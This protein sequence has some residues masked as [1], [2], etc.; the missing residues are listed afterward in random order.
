MGKREEI[1]INGIRFTTQE[2][3]VVD[4]LKKG[5]T[6]R[7]IAEKLSVSVKTIDYHMKNLKEKTKANSRK[8]LLDFF[9]KNKENIIVKK[10]SVL[11]NDKRFLRALI[12]ILGVLLA[13]IVAL[14]PREHKSL[15][16][17]NVSNFS[18]NFLN[19]PHVEDKIIQ[20][21]KWQKGIRTVVIFGT[22]GAGKTTVARKVVSLLKGD[23]KFEINA[24]TEKT[25][26]NSFMELADHL[27]VTPDQR[28]EIDIIRNLREVEYRK[29]RLVRLISM[30]L[31]QK[32]DWV[33]LIDNV[34]LFE[35][36]K[37]YFPA[38][39]EI[40]GRGC[41]LI[42]TRN[43][44]LG[45]NNY[46]KRESMVNIGRLEEQEK[47][48]LFSNIVFGKEF[49]KLD[50]EDR[51]KIS[52]FL[53]VVPEFPLDVCAVAY[54]IKNTHIS[55]DEYS[56]LLRKSINE[57]N[58][59][60]RDLIRENSG[61]SETRYGIIT[62]SLN[63][64]LNNKN[65]YKLLLLTLCLLDSQNI[66]KYLLKDIAG[67]INAENFM[68]KLRERSLVTESGDEISI[69]RSNHKIGYDYVMEILTED[70]LAAGVHA[71]T[72]VLF[73]KSER[74]LTLLPHLESMLSKISGVKGKK[75]I[76][77]KSKLLT[78]MAEILRA[79][80][81][82]V[83]EALACLNRVIS[84]NDK[85]KYLDVYSLA[86]VKSKIGEIYTVMNKNSLADEYLSESLKVFQDNTAE[87]VH[88]YTMLGIVRM[89]QKKFEQ[90]NECFTT[91][92]DQLKSARIGEIEKKL[93]ESTIYENMSFNYFMD[94]INRSNAR[95][96]VGIMRKAIKVLSHNKFD[97]FEEA[98]TRR[99]VQK[100]KL[101]GIYNALALYQQALDLAQEVEDAINKSGYD[102]ADTLY[103]KGIIARERGLANLRLN[104][105][106][107]A[108]KYFDEAKSI[109]TKLMKGD[110]LFKL[111]CHE[112]E[113]L[114]R[115][116]RL[117]EA[118]R[119]CEN[120][121]GEKDRERN[122]Y[123]DLFYDTCLYHAAVAEFRR[124]NLSGSQK[125]FKDFFKSVKVLCREILTESTYRD[126]EK[127]GAF[128]ENP[129]EM[130]EY[131]EN[132]LEVFEAIYWKDYEL[133]K[134]YVEKNLLLPKRSDSQDDDGK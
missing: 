124:K 48:E 8:E 26:Y 132:S 93:L 53:I 69:H 128:N 64:V 21:L 125:Y 43:Q 118:V 127:R 30:L 59:E 86:K 22:G 92:L 74:K 40:W 90:S 119:V 80:S 16:I 129:K 28:R 38:N 5:A 24:E 9:E 4:E 70:E 84:L 66:P 18:D 35:G 46:I 85:H 57:L 51:K 78:L 31:K 116:N 110:Y 108:Y 89:R 27:V 123:S 33:L 29:K 120:V 101:A 75:I 91:A 54:Y 62:S 11:S 107:K 50:F 77:D 106:S 39:E 25:L 126:L 17:T 103:V 82:R 34:G 55:L 44:N 3:S 32:D 113:C 37:E 20:K 97:K 71:I 6:Y 79:K 87:K 42:T 99:N 14:Y 36:I 131:F 88:A 72:D 63:E 94:G 121:F 96:A 134:Y 76:T 98:V 56:Q 19:R 117:D 52:E 105:V 49:A 130:R 111:K 81:Y 109:F 13:V 102:N 45:D 83:G 114:I 95:T 115:L 67:T 104:R 41:V 58:A 122:N 7:E 10:V 61:Y 23:V 12:I 65:E 133:T 47:R 73:D 1:E 68:R 60:Q 2:M 15:E 100:A 112:A